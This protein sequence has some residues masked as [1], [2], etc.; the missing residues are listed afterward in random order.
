[1]DKHQ[2]SKTIKDSV[3]D[4][5]DHG[6]NLASDNDVIKEI[7]IIKYLASANNIREIY[8]AKKC[9]VMF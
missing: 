3:I 4:V 6:V 2:I 9:I 8:K 7:P 1:V 5:I